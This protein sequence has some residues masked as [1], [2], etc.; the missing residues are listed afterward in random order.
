MSTVFVTVVVEILSTH[1]PTIYN[2]NQ[3]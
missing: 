3:V 2:L 1:V